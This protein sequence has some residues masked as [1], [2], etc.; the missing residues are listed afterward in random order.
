MKISF[1][2]ETE[3]EQFPLDYRVL[4]MSYLKYCLS[5]YENGKYL[6]TY[7]GKNCRKKAF[8][9]SVNLGKCSFTK[10]SLTVPGKRFTLTMSYR[11]DE[12]AIIFYNA[13]MQ[14]KKNLYPMAFGNMMKLKNAYMHRE[15]PIDRAQILC[16]TTMPIVVRDHNRETNKDWY[17]SFQNEQF[18]TIL[19][20]N[21][22][23]NFV[24]TPVSMKKT[25]V[26]F[27]GLSI[28]CSVGTFVL[29]GDIETLGDLYRTGLG[30]RTACGFGTF[31][32]IG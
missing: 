19:L 10:E 22:G 15:I 14:Q 30:S 23:C 29:Q 13:L 4:I 16:R 21:T 9:F 2:F 32:I 27:H 20:R 31:D 5:L 1:N 7:Y 11:D 12:T 24:F 3:Q 18:N 17:Y 8:C 25:V 26:T 6:D 28:E